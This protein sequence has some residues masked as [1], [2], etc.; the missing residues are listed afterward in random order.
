MNYDEIYMQR[1]IELG[2]LGM[3]KTYP[4]PTV[5]S[6]IVHKDKIIGEGW[7]KEAGGPH[8]EVNAINSVEDTSLL[9][10]A[11][12]YVSLEPCA[13]QGKTPACVDLI[14][15]HSIPRVIIGCEDPF[16]KVSGRSI[17]KLRDAGVEVISGILERKCIESHKRFFCFN[18]NKRPYIILKWAESA[19]GF[20]APTNQKKGKPF[21]ITSQDSKTYVHKWRTEEASILVGRRTAEMDNPFL[22]AR[23]WK[24]NQ[25]LRLVIDPELKLSKN[26]NLFDDK[27][28]TWVFSKKIKENNLTNKFIQIPFEYSLQEMMLILYKKEISS[29]LVEGGRETIQNFID[30]NLWDEARVFFSFKE[31]GSGISAPNIKGTLQS[32]VNIS[33]D[34]LKTYIR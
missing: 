17:K 1:C 13:H 14:L 11:T 28:E 3:G 12:L 18:S 24:G 27:S 21:W 33:S 7:H 30:Q 34:K 5:G 16:E 9:Y 23:K 15:K 25:P 4:N 10:S 29:I 26:L 32:E 8:A 6:V 31:I 22:T 19:D 2:S 20:I